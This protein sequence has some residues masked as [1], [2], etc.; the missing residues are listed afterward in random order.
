MKS[1][2]AD[3]LWDPF[4][5]PSNQLPIMPIPL[6]LG[7]CGMGMYAILP[8]TCEEP[9]ASTT[10]VTSAGQVVDWNA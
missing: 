9:C 2:A 10:P 4:G 7:P 3:P 6:P 5:I 8:M 1:A